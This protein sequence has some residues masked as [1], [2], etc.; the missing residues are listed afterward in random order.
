MLVLVRDVV[1]GKTQQQNKLISRKN[2][3]LKEISKPSDIRFRTVLQ[4]RSE[5]NSELST[6]KVWRLKQLDLGPCLYSQYKD[7]SLLLKSSDFIVQ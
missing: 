2:K 1:A 5:P 3:L 4:S 6:R 7:R